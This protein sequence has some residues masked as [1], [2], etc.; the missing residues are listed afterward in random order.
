M[1]QKQVDAI[2]Y[3]Y[4]YP[5][6]FVLVLVYFVI[7]Y[8]VLAPLFLSVCKFLARKGLLH[9]ITEKEPSKSQIYYEIRHSLLSVFIFG[10]SGIPII[11]LI[12]TD[13][14][15]L[16][17]DSPLNIITGLLLL[18]LWNEIHF[19]IVHRIMHLPFF[20]KRVH[21]VHHRSIIPTVYSVYSFHW[22]EA[23][24][25]STVPVTLAP[26]VPLA[27]LAIFLFPLV[28]VLLNYSG[29]CNFRFGHGKGADWKLFGTY[30][31]QHH[32]KGRRNYGF[33]SH[34]LDKLNEKISRKQ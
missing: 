11:Y 17:A 6:I 16:L 30:H 33:A 27:P 32:S 29:H 2:L 15:T 25:L 1:I 14:I 22:F 7:L 31:H 18:T 20:M 28:S 34:L 13:R 12:R 26:F 5:Q 21:F 23:L 10:F 8:L 9:R 19:F 3:E 4:S 24:L